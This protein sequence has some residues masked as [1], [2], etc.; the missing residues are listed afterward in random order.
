MVIH[1]GEIYWVVFAGEGSEPRAVVRQSFCNTTGLT[2]AASILWSS[3]HSPHSCVTPPCPVMSVCVRA[4]PTCQSR[5]L[6]MSPRFRRLTGPTYERRL[7]R[8]PGVWSARYGKESG[9][10]WRQTAR[11]VHKRSRPSDMLPRR[12]SVAAH[13]LD[14]ASCL[15]ALWLDSRTVAGLHRGEEKTP[16]RHATEKRRRESCQHTNPKSATCC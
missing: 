9:W 12:R 14:S 10:C 6:S 3:Q 1:Q 4:R 7:A 13:P 15:Y 16:E 2:T 5:A 8:S 11:T